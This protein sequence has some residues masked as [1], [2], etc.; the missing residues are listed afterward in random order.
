MDHLITDFFNAI[1]AGD[2]EEV[3]RFLAETPDLLQAVDSR[4]SSAL[5]LAT[6][7]DHLPMAKWLLE[8]GATVNFTDASGNT[9]LMGVCFKGSVPLV[10]LLILMELMSM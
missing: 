5:I 9:A 3:A 10:Q 1:R 4:G 2:K 8:K 6:Y 7:Y